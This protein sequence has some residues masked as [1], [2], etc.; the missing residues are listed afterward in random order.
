[1]NVFRR[2]AELLSRRLVFKRNLPNEFGGGPIF[3]SPD[4]GLRFYWKDL[5]R[6]DA[7]LFRMAAELVR[8]GD[9]VWDI[10][11]N[12]GLFSFAAAALTG[13]KGRVLAVEP[14]TWLVGLLHRSA[15]LQVSGRAEVTVVPAA[16]SDCMGLVKLHI[17]ARGRLSNF[18]A[19]GSE[20]TQAGGTRKTECVVAL[21]L[22]FLS[23][24]FPMPQ[25]LKIDV[26]GV[27]NLVLAGGVRLLKEA[28]PRILCEV[29]AKNSKRVT[30]LLQDANYR[31]FDATHHPGQRKELSEATWD[32]LALPN[33][34][35]SQVAS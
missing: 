19:A 10:G 2:T 21:T 34:V 15:S 9:T 14:D 29:S 35:M 4:S 17:A 26:E 27:E 30:R 3:V 8:P 28:R 5:R 33:A 16:A 20:S 23:Q 18:I 24:H 6:T 1:M 32:T 12:L 31:I 13:P 25:V 11:A 7:T 22:D